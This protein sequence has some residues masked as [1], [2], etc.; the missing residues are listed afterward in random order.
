MQHSQV[1][2]FL[3]PKWLREHRMGLS[4]LGTMGLWQH[5]QEE[6]QLSQLELSLLLLCPQTLPRF[7][8]TA[9]GLQLEQDVF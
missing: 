8:A 2:K 7:L 4:L 1:E 9:P 6:A 3:Y 5:P